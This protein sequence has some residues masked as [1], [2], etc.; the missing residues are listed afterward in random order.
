MATPTLGTVIGGV[1]SGTATIDLTFTMAVGDLAVMFF[2]ANYYDVLSYMY[3]PTSPSGVTTAYEG[4]ADAGDNK[5]HLR[6][7]TTKCTSAGSKTF[8]FWPV[9]DCETMAIIVPLSGTTLAKDGS[10]STVTSAV[11]GSGLTIPAVSPTTA[12]AILVACY[13]GN[14]NGTPTWSTPTGMTSR[15]TERDPSPFINAT[16]FT[17]VLSASGSTGT[18]ASTFSTNYDTSAAAGMLAIKSTAGGAP[19][20][21]GAFLPFF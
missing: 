9:N 16:A 17:Q 4:M 3:D 14:N 1:Q 8:T 11:A 19:A 21:P 13:I 6:F 7:Y 18:R 5:C 10:L 12:D 20:R 15:I 2:G